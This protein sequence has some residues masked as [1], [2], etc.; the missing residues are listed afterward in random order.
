[1]VI[2][3]GLYS[4]ILKW[5]LDTV[6][7]VIRDK[8][9]Q[10]IQIVLEAIKLRNSIV[11]KRF[12]YSWAAAQDVL[13]LVLELEIDLKKLV[14]ET[15]AHENRAERTR[16]FLAK[17]GEDFHPR[18]LR[19]LKKIRGKFEATND[20]FSAYSLEFYGFLSL[21]NAKRLIKHSEADR[22]SDV[23]R[24][25]RQLWDTYATVMMTLIRVSSSDI[26]FW[27]TDATYSDIAERYAKHDRAEIEKLF[28]S[29]APVN[30]A[31]SIEHHVMVAE[32]WE[33]V[34]P[35]SEK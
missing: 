29:K 15:P 5:G 21:E 31:L 17:L 30:W 19:R 1:M 20:L 35:K 11:Q 28:V 22:L 34:Q 13:D 9:P 18:F 23:A 33:S 16:A 2:E 10:H 3:A 8:D 6:S 25:Y 32:F 24:L 26:R 14:D 27:V 12:E 7:S 4:V